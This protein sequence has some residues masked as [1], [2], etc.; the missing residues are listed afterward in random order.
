MR[1]LQDER[2]PPVLFATH[3][4]RKRFSHDVGKYS[5][6]LIQR[7]H[8][9]DLLV[10]DDLVSSKALAQP[11]FVCR[12]GDSDVAVEGL[13]HLNRK[14][15]DTARPAIDENLVGGLEI[16]R[17]ALVRYERGRPSGTRL[18]RGNA[19]RQHDDTLV[20]RDHVLGKGYRLHW[21][22][23]AKHTLPRADVDDLA[24][25]SDDTAAQVHAW[26]SGKRNYQSGGGTELDGKAVC[27]VDT[28]GT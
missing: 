28:G 15:L 5:T 3:G 25:D 21:T 19:H 16:W 6:L 23:A 12:A 9:V 17:D 2:L 10:I 26:C 22:Q 4:R 7:I 13:S 8:D 20:G 14:G 11:N 27:F 24:T 18:P 1:V